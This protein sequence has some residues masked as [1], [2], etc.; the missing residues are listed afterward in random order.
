MEDDDDLYFDDG[1]IG[2]PD[3]PE[4]GE[5]F[6]ESVFDDP[7]HPLY[8][9]PA[10]AM[11]SP[12]LAEAGPDSG[13]LDAEDGED[14]SKHGLVPHPSMRGQGRTFQAA[15]DPFEFSD[16][17]DY[18]SALVEA[19]HQAEADGRF[20]RKNSVA[21]TNLSLPGKDEEDGHDEQSR[22]PIRDSQ[23]TAP[24]LVPDSGRVSGA[25]ETFASDA[26]D[27]FGSM[28]FDADAYGDDFGDGFDDYD[29]ALEDDPIIA[30]ANAEALA[31]DYEG[32]YGSEFGFYAAAN[33]VDGSVYGGFFG[34]R[35]ALGRSISGRNALPQAQAVQANTPQ[36][37]PSLHPALRNWHG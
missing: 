15:S 11:K 12:P 23:D 3:L 18:F 5:K 29:S 35:D 14:L 2:E 33:G 6:D 37:V 20:A 27:D 26:L 36:L 24:S 1:L 31:N 28:G 9:R 4:D 10:P 13:D 34:P 25:T 22:N 19:T 16:P 32:E 21:T 17:Q 30:A 7:T 8:E